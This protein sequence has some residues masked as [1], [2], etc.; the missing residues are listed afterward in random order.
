MAQDTYAQLIEKA[1]TGDA[2]AL[3]ALFDHHGALLRGRI[4]RWLSPALR[5]KMSHADIIQEAYLVALERVTRFEDRSEGDF[6]TWLAQIVEFKTRE[7][8]RK[9]AG[10]AKRGAVAEVSRGG[11]ADTAHFIGRT[12]SPSQMAIAGETREAAREALE[13]LPEDYRT[14]LRLLQEEHLDMD[15]AAARMERSRDA[16]KKL[17]GRALS[18]FAEL[19]KLP[20]GRRNG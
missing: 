8:V 17:Y 9:Y 16:T 1:R 19:L 13:R 3:N 2:D 15:Q 14:V 18:R 20:P 12:P 11:R 7:V 6:G 10:T 5:R 4:R